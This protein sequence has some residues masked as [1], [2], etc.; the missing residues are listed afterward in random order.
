MIS[1]CWHKFVNCF[2]LQIPF[3]VFTAKS[4]LK[5]PH[6]MSC[7]WL[8][9]IALQWRHN[10]HDGISNH[11]PHDCLFNC[12]FRRRSKKKSKLRVTGL[13]VG[14]SLGTSEF[15][16]N[17]QL[18]RKCFHL[19][20]SSWSMKMCHCRKAWCNLMNPVTMDLVEALFEYITSVKA[21]SLAGILLSQK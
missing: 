11:Q 19:M 15:H 14:N 8:P 9:S 20:T 13:C 10:G 7:A 6:Q 18:R 21:F 3:C 12:L 16:T 1:F 2:W 17:G 4:R 5:I